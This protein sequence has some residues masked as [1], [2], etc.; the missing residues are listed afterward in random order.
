MSKEL[1]PLEALTYLKENKRKHW[2]DN[3]KSSECL[4]IIEKEIKDCSAL[5]KNTQKV[6]EIANNKLKKQDEV[7]RIIKEKGLHYLEI[8]MFISDLSY[9]EYV[10]ETQREFCFRPMIDSK[11]KTQAEF[12]LLKEVLK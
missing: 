3:D 1:T 8:A 2:L 10:I 12:N 5:K 11:L 6:L 9:E 7:L 4:D